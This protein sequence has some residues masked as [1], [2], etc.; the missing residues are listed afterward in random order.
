MTI[1]HSTPIAA[2]P[3]VVW[4]VTEDVERWPEWQPTVTSVRRLDAGPFRVGSRARIKQPLQPE[5]TWTVTDHAPGRRF[6]WESVRPGL[7]LVGTHD[8]APDGAGASSRLRVEATGPLAVLLWP[9]LGPATR[10]SLRQENAGL[11]RRCEAGSTSPR[12]SEAS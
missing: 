12:V 6:S 10:W 5:A 8:V 1:E 11:R 2:P 7:R 9:L 3:D 4:A